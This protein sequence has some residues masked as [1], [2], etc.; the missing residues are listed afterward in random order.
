M[1]AD[2]CRKHQA[3]L[4]LCPGALRTFESKAVQGQNKITFRGHPFPPLSQPLKGGAH[5]CS[6]AQEFGLFRGSCPEG[7]DHTY[8]RTFGR[9]LPPFGQLLEGGAHHQLVVKCQRRQL[10]HWEPLRIGRIVLQGSKLWGSI[11]LQGRRSVGS[12]QSSAALFL[13]PSGT[14]TGVATDVCGS[15]PHW[16]RPCLPTRMCRPGA[17]KQGCR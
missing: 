7:C 1:L 2:G 10:P 17:A 8:C 9:H 11:K 5:H 15:R 13:V 16:V 6:C 14:V 4:Q 3:T 12:Q